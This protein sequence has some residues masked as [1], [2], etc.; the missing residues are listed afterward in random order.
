[1]LH[2]VGSLVTDVSG[3]PIGSIFKEPEVKPVLLGVLDPE[4]LGL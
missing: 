2:S 3:E 4:S 1:M